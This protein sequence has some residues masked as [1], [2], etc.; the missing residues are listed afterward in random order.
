MPAIEKGVELFNSHHFWHAHEA[1]EERWLIATGDEKLFLQGL[2]QL[3]AA[4]HH[5]Q[6]GTFS[7]AIRL[8]D[9]AFAK[10][11]PFPPGHAGVDRAAAVET[12]RRHRTRIANGDEIDAREYPRLALQFDSTLR[13]TE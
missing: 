2:I 11:E 6:R 7:G 5:V 13:P 4:Y 3:A 12:A 1:W 10:L 8:F 9:A